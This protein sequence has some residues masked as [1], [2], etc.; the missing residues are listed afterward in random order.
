[1]TGG[2]SSQSPDAAPDT[3]RQ[4]GRIRYLTTELVIALDAMGGDD[5]PRIVIEGA[6][7]AQPRFPAAR[8]LLFGDEAVLKPL[9]QGSEPLAKVCQIRHTPEAIGS[10]DAPAQALRRGRGSSMGLAVQSVRDGEA[11]VVVSAGNTGALMAMAKFMF[12]TMAG[13]S[14]PA[15]ASVLPTLKGET[16]MLDLGANVECDEENLIQFAVMGAAY[17][18]VLLH[19]ERPRVCLLNVGAEELKGNESVKRAS[20]VLRETPLPLEFAGFV[21]GDGI[22]KGA[23]DVIVT[24]GFTGN[25][26]LKT[27]EGIAHLAFGL[28]KKAFEH[29]ALTRVGYVLAKPGLTVLRN[30]L[31]P[32]NH[33]GAVLI[34]LNGLVVKSHGSATAAGFAT[35]IGVAANMVRDQL[36]DRIA[37]DLKRVYP[38]DPGV[39]RAALS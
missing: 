37:E 32:S 16:V 11:A 2:K 38:S 29:S 14:R 4:H 24:D 5:A 31:D 12:K 17:A 10:A 34:G 36:C 18:R 25:V 21:E 7:L 28:L 20:Q 23:A 1:M 27:A 6:R 15:L 33:N 19:V 3:K 9:L 8:F 13:I 35:A 22:G 26:A 30:H 39:T